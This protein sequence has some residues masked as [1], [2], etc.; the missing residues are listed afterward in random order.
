MLTR[1]FDEW[2][3]KRSQ[4]ATFYRLDFLLAASFRRWQEEHL[5]SIYP[6]FR[7]SKLPALKK[8]LSLYSSTLINPIPFWVVIESGY[9]AF[10]FADKSGATTPANDT[11]DNQVNLVNDDDIR[12]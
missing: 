12:A 10:D 3:E 4:L 1:V 11:N 9:L 2:K 6:T 7:R 8:V 5:T